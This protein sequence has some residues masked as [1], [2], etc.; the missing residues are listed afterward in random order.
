MK[1]FPN[2]CSS[3]AGEFICEANSRDHCWCMKFPAIMKNN[4]QQNCECPNCL[5]KSIAN[6]LYVYISENELVDVLQFAEKYKYQSIHEHIDYTIE[7]GNYV[8]TE[9]YHLK[10]GECCDNGCQ[11]CPFGID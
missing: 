3:C 9:W 5:S 7:N 11:K 10:R 8:F 1:I 4:T 6:K 2:N